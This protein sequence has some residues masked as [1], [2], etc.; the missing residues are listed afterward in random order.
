MISSSQRP[1]PDNSQHSQQTN[2]HDPEEIRT[3]NLLRRP[4]ADLRL[5][6]AATGIDCSMDTHSKQSQ[7]PEKRKI[8]TDVSVGE[9]STP[10]QRTQ[11]RITECPKFLLWEAERPS[12]VDA[13]TLLMAAVCGW[14]QQL[15]FHNS[16]S[17]VDY[18]LESPT[19]LSTLSPP[20]LNVLN[21]FTINSHKTDTDTCRNRIKWNS[22][23]ENG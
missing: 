16:I 5:D 8:R 1:L 9:P 23:R 14:V 21:K 4:V 17:S 15:S 11:Y 13:E 7:I 2:L 3:H 6:I 19:T 18:L 12:S 10:T 22:T 20:H